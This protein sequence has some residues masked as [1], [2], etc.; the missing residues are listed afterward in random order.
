L[1]LI[2]ESTR[3]CLAIR[4]G[5]CVRAPEVIETLSDAMLFHRIP[6]HIR[7]D[8]GSEMTS[9]RVRNWLQQMGTQTLFNRARLA[10]GERLQRVLQRQTQASMLKQRDLLQ[11]QKSTNHHR[12]VVHTLQHPKT[13]FST[14]LQLLGTGDPSYQN[15]PNQSNDHHPLNSKHSHINWTTLSG[16]SMCP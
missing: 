4:V 1:T 8:S 7:S 15:Y 2:D 5:R 10:L 13:P 12:T 16:R 3:E 9:I 11:S 6:E 14:Q